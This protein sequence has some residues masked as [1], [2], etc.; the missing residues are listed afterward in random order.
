M[1]RI[2][3]GLIFAA[4]PVF[5]LQATGE[6]AELLSDTFRETLRA[7]ANTGG[8]RVMGFQITGADPLTDLQAL[9][10]HSWAGEPFCVRTGTSDGL[11]DSENTY[12]APNATSAAVVVPHVTRS[13]HAKALDALDPQGFGVRI[14]RNAC[15]ETSADSP[16]ALALWRAAEAADR[17]SVFVNS[18]DADR[19][20]A[21]TAG[22]AAVE[23]DVINADI[24]VAFDRVCTIP[25]EMGQGLMT[26]RLVP[27]KD[28]LRGLTEFLTIELP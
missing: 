8:A 28:G 19:L 18:F 11:Y 24:S 1:R 23:C 27:F 14:Q 25:F 5:P 9:V 2:A 16:G 6:T 20:V 10:P 17:F 7:T 12:R 26:V 21:L 3:L 4:L 22:G 15:D 13:N